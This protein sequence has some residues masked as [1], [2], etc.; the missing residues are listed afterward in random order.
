M[1]VLVTGKGTGGSWQVRGEQLGAAIG[2][3]VVPKATDVAGYDL[4]ILV[5]RPEPAL[6]Q[7]LHA[8]RVPIVWDVVDAYPQPHGNR[9]ERHE[10]LGWLSEAVRIIRPAAIVAATRAMAADCAGFGL[11]VLALPHHAWPGQGTCC[12]GGQIRSVGYQ[13]AENYL[14]GWR[15]F[16][17]AECARRGWRFVINPTSVSQV[18]VVVAVRQFDG[19][20]ARFWKSN[21]KLANA[22]GCG[23]PCVMN[24]EAGYLETA[25][26]AER[27]ADTEAE[28]VAAFDSLVTQKARVEAS[29]A[30][31]QAAP[32]LR[33]VA[34]TYTAWLQTLSKS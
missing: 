29:A 26:G 34:T 16:L 24:R 1:R 7:R 19:Y 23:T 8:A 5:K 2:T 4:A 18:D 21:V 32:R 3:A 25:C 9:W 10:C 28:M 6:V 11:P 30:L 22:Q 12:V 17:E 31:A 20:A 33:A 13:G 27:W 14:G 15:Q